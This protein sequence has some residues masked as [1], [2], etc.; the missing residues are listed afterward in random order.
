[1]KTQG[2]APEGAEYVSADA[3][4]SGGVL[5]SATARYRKGLFTR[6]GAA[7]TVQLPADAKVLHFV[8]EI[9]AG[10]NPPAGRF[11]VLVAGKEI[12]SKAVTADA[13]PE[14]ANVSLSG[15]EAVTLVYISNPEG[16]IGSVGVWGDAFVTTGK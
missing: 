5:R 10:S 9:A 12:W 8:P 11:A 1:V 4:P 3:D 7:V 16:L 14:P 6:A 15:A 2:F 13:K